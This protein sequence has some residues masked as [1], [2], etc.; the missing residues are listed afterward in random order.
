MPILTADELKQAYHDRMP[1]SWIERLAAMGRTVPNEMLPTLRVYFAQQETLVRR[2][3]DAN[4][5][6]QS[7]SALQRRRRDDAADG[8]GQQ[9]EQW[10]HRRQCSRHCHID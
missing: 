9:Q 2:I 5:A 1:N 3:E 8:H 4:N 7:Q 10:P 6:Q